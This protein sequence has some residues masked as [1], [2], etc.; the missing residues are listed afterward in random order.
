MRGYVN[1]NVSSTTYIME[2]ITFYNFI[3]ITMMGRLVRKQSEEF[4]YISS[5]MYYSFMLMT[6]K[7]KRY[8]DHYAFK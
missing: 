7:R 8:I 6:Q 4:L 5:I 3:V 1:S 2:V